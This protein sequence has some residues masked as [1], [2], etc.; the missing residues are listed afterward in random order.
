MKDIIVRELALGNR[1]SKV[2]L[3]IDLASDEY[4]SVHDAFKLA[5][6]DEKAINKE[7]LNLYE[8]YDTEE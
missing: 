3:I 8:Y 7:L 5:L 2:E 1:E 4:E 6:M